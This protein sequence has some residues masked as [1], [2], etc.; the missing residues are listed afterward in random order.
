VGEEE[1]KNSSKETG[2]L[3]DKETKRLKE[4]GRYYNSTFSLIRHFAD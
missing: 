2:R 3:K 1:V 4:K